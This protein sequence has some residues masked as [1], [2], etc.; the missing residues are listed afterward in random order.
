M[1]WLAVAFGGA[2]GAMARFGLTHYWL[3]VNAK[4]FPWGTLTANVIGSL[5]MG[6]CYVVLLEKP[7]LAEHWRPLLMTG[8]LGAFTTYS[9]FALESFL[10]WQQ[11]AITYAIIYSLVS[12]C[13]CIFAV[14]ISI[15]IT[16]QFYH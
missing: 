13:S 16:T 2:L 4:M 15:Y 12:V 5:L 3:P 7:W 1:L 6:I 10:L 8:F 9:A 14:V 11:G